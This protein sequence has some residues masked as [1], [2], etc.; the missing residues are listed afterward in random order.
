M[1]HI[2]FYQLGEASETDTVLTL[3]QKALGTGEKILIYCPRPAATVIDDALWCHDPNSWLPHGLDQA[4]G[5]ELASVWVCSDMASNPIDASHVILLHGAEP[6]SW[7][8]FER[9]FLVFDGSSDAQL[10]Q[11]QS[12]W[13]KWKSQAETELAYFSQRAD[14]KWEKKA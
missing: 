3:V 4:A 11:A 10:H 9:A 2:G 13:Q 8:G 5:A 14:G 12:Q 6:E 7:A 1:L